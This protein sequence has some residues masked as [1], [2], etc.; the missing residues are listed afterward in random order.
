[1]NTSVTC[2]PSIRGLLQILD[3]RFALRVLVALAEV[4]SQAKLGL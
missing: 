4:H 1:M 2:M 3:A